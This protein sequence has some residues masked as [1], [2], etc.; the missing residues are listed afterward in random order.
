MINIGGG[1][2]N[3]RYTRPSAGRRRRQ[4]LINLGVPWLAK[5]AGAV[6]VV[7]W[8]GVLAVAWNDIVARVLAAGILA[9]CLAWLTV[10]ACHDGNA[11]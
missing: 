10:M 6:A 5:V 11:K 1:P 3:L 7:V 2:A 8:A 4:A 9:I